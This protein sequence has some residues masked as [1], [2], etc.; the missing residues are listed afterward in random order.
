MTRV[1]ITSMLALRRLGSAVSTYR[2]RILLGAIAGWFV[3]TVVGAFVLVYAE[4]H[5]VSLEDANI[6]GAGIVWTGVAVG[7]MIAYATRNATPTKE[8]AP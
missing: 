5:W 1:Y 6:L 8:V 2:K 7:A 3:S 4:T